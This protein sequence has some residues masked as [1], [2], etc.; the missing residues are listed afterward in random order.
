[1]QILFVEDDEALGSE[2]QTVLQQADYV[3]TWVTSAE[4]AMAYLQH[5]SVDILLVDIGLPGLSGIEMLR[6][7][8]REKSDIPVMLLTARDTLQDKVRGLD[9]GADDYL[10]KPFDLDELLA[11][12]RALLRR[13]K[14]MVHQIIF[15]GPLQL[16]IDQQ[17]CRYHN[18]EVA[19]S[20]REYKLLLT[21]IQNTGRVLSR[22]YLEQSI[23]GWD[24]DVESNALEVHVH[25]VRK[26]IPM[27]FI[28]TVRGSGYRVDAYKDAK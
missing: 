6:L 2:L 11:R 3:V 14:G 12:L 20:R 18:D 26:K 27:N 13:S 10:L 4:S 5:T 19:L 17:I 7:L 16:D 9:A 1:M 25:N 8:R 21:L 24:E 28:K 23:Y 15:Y 22:E